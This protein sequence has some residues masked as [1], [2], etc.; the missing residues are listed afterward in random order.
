MDVTAS[1]LLWKRMS[2]ETLEEEDKWTQ[3]DVQ[4]ISE[5][6]YFK[7]SIFHLTHLLLH[8]FLWYAAM[9]ASDVGRF[10]CKKLEI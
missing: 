10:F 2:S 4:Q 9:Q 3:E 8:F 1:L 6:K 7:R 5:F